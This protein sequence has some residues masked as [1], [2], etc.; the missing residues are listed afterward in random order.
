MPN[1]PRLMTRTGTYTSAEHKAKRRKEY[2]AARAAR[3]PSRK[4]YTTAR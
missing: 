2:E 4:W 1:K 3:N